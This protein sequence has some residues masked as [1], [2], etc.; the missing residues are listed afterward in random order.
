HIGSRFVLADLRLEHAAKV[1]SI[2]HLRN[3]KVD[4]ERDL[5]VVV[6]MRG[7]LNVYAN[8]EK[9]ELRVHEGT[10]ANTRRARVVAAGCR[11]HLVANLDGSL[12]AIRGADLRCLKHSCTRLVEQCLELCARKRR[13]GPVRRR[14]TAQV[15]EWNTGAGSGSRRGGRGATGGRRRRRGTP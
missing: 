14:E 9:R 13:E 15:A 6:D 3:I 12:R 10:D 7:D 5:I 8:I 4:V 11:R 2:F 1:N